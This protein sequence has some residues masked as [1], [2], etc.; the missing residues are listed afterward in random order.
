MWTSVWNEVREI[1]WLIALVTVLSA[2][3]VGVAIALVTTT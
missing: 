3:G 2:T 1:V